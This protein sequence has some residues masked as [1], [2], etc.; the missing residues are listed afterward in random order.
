MGVRCMG[1]LQPGSLDLYKYSIVLQTYFLFLMI[2]LKTFLVFSFI[3]GTQSMMHKIHEICVNQ[4]F[5][6]EEL[7]VRLRVNSRLL[8]VKSWGS[9]ESYVDFQPRKGLV[10]L[11]L[12]C[13][14]VNRA[15]MLLALLLRESPDELVYSMVTSV[16]MVTI[17][18][19]LN[20]Q[21]WLFSLPIQ[22]CLD[23]MIMYMY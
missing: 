14:K 12:Y 13:L 1:A 21:W 16:P 4:L 6:R 9:Q 17:L 20:G 8:T 5:K 15:P 3:V 2:I 10:V 22:R 19:I 11:T 18:A 7:A 23:E